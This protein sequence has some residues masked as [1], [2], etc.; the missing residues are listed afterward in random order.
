MAKDKIPKTNVM[1]LLE[2][3]AVIYEVF[4]YPWKEDDL[5]ARHVGKEL[6]RNDDEIYKTI[7]L[8]GDKTG[9]I[10]AVI[11]S[12]KSIDL[13]K[14]AKLSENKRV[15]MLPLKDLEKTTGYIRGG[16]SP[17]GMKRSYPTFID[18]AV[19]N[20]PQVLVSAGQRGIQISLCPD[21]LIHLTKATTGNI[22]MEHL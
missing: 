12:N 22:S 5:D 16:C 9:P 10:V 19:C 8:L 1:R 21:S 2:K 4:T 7:L 18:D 15:T 11:P 17:L 13:K 14:L 20:L 6:N 3:S